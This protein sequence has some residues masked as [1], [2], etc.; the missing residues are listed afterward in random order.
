MMTLVLLDERERA[1][2]PCNFQHDWIESFK[3]TGPIAKMNPTRSS[4]QYRQPRKAAI[5]AMEIK[6]TAV[7]PNLLNGQNHFDC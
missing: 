5:P 2:S 7:I 1:V 4:G 3:S 6:M